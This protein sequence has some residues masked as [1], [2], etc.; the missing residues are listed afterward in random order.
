MRGFAAAA[1]S[2]IGMEVQE[3]CVLSISASLVRSPLLPGLHST[4]MRS[5]GPSE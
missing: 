3:L 1:E 4:S 5:N 2:K